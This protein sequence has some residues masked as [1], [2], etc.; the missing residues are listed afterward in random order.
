MSK[1]K[2]DLIR[3]WD[4][5]VIANDG[6]WLW[7]GA[8]N[9]NGYAHFYVPNTP[10]RPVCAH[11]W[12]WQL[13]N[14]P[15]PSGLEIDHLCRVR[16]C[17]NPAHLETISHRLNVLRGTAPPAICARQTHCK[18]GHEFTADNTRYDQGKRRCR[19]CRNTYSKDRRKRAA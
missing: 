14:G 16:R 13:F 4:K 6:C 19:V 18:N 3:F 1:P 2:D 7:T 12:I 11:A 17:V 5:V 9:S 10:S 8:V 15:V